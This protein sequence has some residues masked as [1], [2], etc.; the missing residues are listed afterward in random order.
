MALQLQ[1]TTPDTVIHSEAYFK[2]VETNMNWLNKHANITINIWHDDAA[3][4]GDN[5]ANTIGQVNFQVNVVA[6][7]D[8]DNNEIVPTFDEIFGASAT[9]AAIDYIQSAGDV[10]SSQNILVTCVYLWIVTKEDFKEYDF[11][12]AIT[13]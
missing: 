13:V 11:T 3:R 1:I 2:V 5:P 10:L 6:Q 4:D 9:Q 12:Q 8:K 7:V